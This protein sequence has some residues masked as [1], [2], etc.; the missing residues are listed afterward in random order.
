MGKPVRKGTRITVELIV[1]HLAD[2]RSMEEILKSYLSLLREANYAAL[3]FA[4]N[5]LRVSYVSP[6]AS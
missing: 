4:A 2:S 1:E 3:Q 6:I 5:H